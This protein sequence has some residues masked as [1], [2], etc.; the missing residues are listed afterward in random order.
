MNAEPSIL[1][2]VARNWWVTAIRGALAIIFGL[3]AFFFPR[4][5]LFLLTYLFA[6]FCLLDG[7]FA[8]VTGFQARRLL[9]HTTWAPLLE[10]FFSIAIGLIALLLPAIMITVFIY[11][12]AGWAIVTGILKIIAAFRQKEQIA[13]EWPLALVG[14]ISIIFGIIFCLRPHLGIRIVLW[15]IGTFALVIGVALLFQAFQTHSLKTDNHPPEF[16]ENI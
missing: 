1:N 8:I 11:M 15:M 14:L 12:I 5:T 7:I 10:G 4:M 3:A 13:P 16:F 6:A 9:R 2:E